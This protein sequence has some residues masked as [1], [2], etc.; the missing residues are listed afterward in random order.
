MT[1]SAR[2]LANVTVQRAYLFAPHASRFPAVR[3]KPG[4]DAWLAD[5]GQNVSS[6]GTVGA[7]RFTH[8]GCFIRL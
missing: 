1:A 8:P 2:V 3:E 6:A 7:L 4:A 5:G